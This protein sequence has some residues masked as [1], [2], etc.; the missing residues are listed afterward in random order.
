MK[1]YPAII[2]TEQLLQDWNKSRWDEYQLWINQHSLHSVSAWKRQ[3]QHDL[4]LQNPPKLSI[5]TPVFNTAPEILADCI[6][7]VRTQSYPYWQLVL[8]DDGSS[9]P[10]TLQV[11]RSSLCQDPRIQVLFGK[12]SQGI[13]GATNHAISIATGDY[14]LFLDHD[15]RL[16]LDALSLIANAIHADPDLDIVYSDR[17]MLSERG[18]RYFH[19]FKPDWSPETLLSGNYIFHLMCYRRALL[20]RLHGLRPEYDGSQDYDLILRAAETS[21]KVKHISEVL[22]HWRQHNT[23]VSLNEDAKDFAFQAGIRAL[24]SALERRG[25]A[26][27]AKEI[28]HFSRGTYALDLVLPNNASLQVI[29]LTEAQLGDQYANTITQAIELYSDSSKPYIAI[30][31]DAITPETITTLTSLAAWLNFEGV[32]LATGKILN[33]Q[34]E[35]DYV[36]MSY[37]KDTTLMHPYQSFSETEPGYMRVTQIARNISAPH[38]HCVVFKRSLWR[39]LKGFHPLLQG[40][41]ALLDFALRAITANQRCVIVPQC[42]FKLQGNTFDPTPLSDDQQLFKH[43]WHKAMQHGDPYY[44]SNLMEKTA[45]MGLSL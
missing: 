44:N 45:Y 29:S 22:Y 6:L 24:N 10:E 26:G 11:L 40:P 42:R 9:N 4:L 8:A 14:V 25:I 3:H 41:H 12:K 27:V 31:S 2:P 35:L 15:D 18:D 16:A 33:P 34:G 39:E 30:L 23:S 36:G 5:V 20:T 21:P 13:S 1:Y 43:L 19:L 17:D 38:P 37:N 32:G 7:S 28:P